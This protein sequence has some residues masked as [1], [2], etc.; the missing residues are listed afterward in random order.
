MNHPDD[1]RERD[2]RDLESVRAD[3]ASGLGAVRYVQVGRDRERRVPVPLC[4][5]EGQVLAEADGLTIGMFRAAPEDARFRF[6]G[7][8][9]EHVV[10]FPWSFVRIRHLGREPFVADPNTVTLFNPEQVYYREEIDPRGDQ[11][12][13]I[14]VSVP[15]LRR[16]L[17]PVAAAQPDGELWPASYTPIGEDAYLLAFLLGD[18]LLRGEVETGL[19]AR[20]AA[21]LLELV[22]DGLREHLR[23]LQRRG[24]RSG[25]LRLVSAARE[26]LDRRWVDP[27][28]VEA[29]AD[30]LDAS[31]SK[32]CRAFNA[33]LGCTAHQY[34]IQL[35]LRAALHRL[36]SADGLAPLALEL[37][38]ANHSHFSASFRKAY[39]LTPSRVARADPARLLGTLLQSGDA[40]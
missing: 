31:I 4:N 9:G 34:L 17:G 19:A 12:L 35:R 7:L 23:R 36:R 26:I 28:G 40:A 21:R 27:P 1:E 20:A 3:A 25:N 39:G 33:V 6:S 32:L 8:P 16:T 14:A 38:F 22:V 24:G 37:G 30:E 5:N 10:G 11:T 15:R 13:W 2:L 18:G 29:L